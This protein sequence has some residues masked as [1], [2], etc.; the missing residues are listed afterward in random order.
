MPAK[1]APFLCFA[2]ANFFDSFADLQIVTVSNHAEVREAVPQPSLHQ[3]RYP[4]GCNATISALIREY[5]SH[6]SV[7][8]LLILT[9]FVPNLWHL[10]SSF[11]FLVERHMQVCILLDALLTPQEIFLDE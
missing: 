6:G 5:T 11:E 3:L 1:A 4:Q 9:S 10:I 8:R 7:C 2:S